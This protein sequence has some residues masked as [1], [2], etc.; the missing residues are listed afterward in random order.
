[1]PTLDFWSALL[2]QALLRGA[3]LISKVE[4]SRLV[5]F[6]FEPPVIK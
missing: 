1:M 5:P 6:F 4:G 3:A 2:V